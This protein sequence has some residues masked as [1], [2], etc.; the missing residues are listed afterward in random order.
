LLRLIACL[1][2]LGAPA[3]AADF[4]FVHAPG[5]AFRGSDLATGALVWIP[6]TYGKDQTGPPPPPDYVG[7]EAAMEMDIWEFNRDRDD[8]PLERGAEL[9]AR[10]LRTL[11]DEMGYRR[12][13]V[14]GHSRG[15][16]IALTALAH[17]DLADAV[18]AFSPAAHGT[19]EARKA[20]AMADWTSLWDA[21]VN[22]GARVVLV[23]LADDPWDPDPARRLAIACDRFGSNLLSIFQP[24]QPKGH[25]GVYEPAFDEQ[26]GTLIARFIPHGF[27]DHSLMPRPNCDA[28]ARH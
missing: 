10:G 22:G 18:V 28:A 3:N 8:D 21:A 14:A 17:P 26:F 7:R 15:A 16:W 6:G 4:P 1:L 23:Q 20:R 24:A 2:L 5:F 11:R 19:A 27:P 12:I 25:A 9:L 13:I